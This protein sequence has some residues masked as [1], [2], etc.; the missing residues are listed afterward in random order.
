[1]AQFPAPAT[2]HVPC[3]LTHYAAHFTAEVMRPIRL[4]RLQ[5]WMADTIRELDP[6]G[7]TNW[8]L[9]KED[10]QRLKARI[11]QE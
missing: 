1:M 11:P 10:R 7:W 6:N 2:S 3:G 9:S 4:D 8:L 5:S